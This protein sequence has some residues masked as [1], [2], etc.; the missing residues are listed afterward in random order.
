M[1]SVTASS[2]PA[3]SIFIIIEVPER[4]RPETTTMGPFLAGDFFEE[5]SLSMGEDSYQLSVFSKVVVEENPFAVSGR[6]IR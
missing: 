6:E 1:E 4:G 2:P 3:W 5:K